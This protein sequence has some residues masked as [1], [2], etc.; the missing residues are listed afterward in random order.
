[1][2]GRAAATRSPP[3]PLA[4]TCTITNT[5]TSATLILQKQWVN[6]A[7]GDTAGLTIATPAPGTPASATSTATGAAGSET[8]T[9]NRAT[10]TVFSGQTVHPGRDA[11]CREHR[12]VHLADRL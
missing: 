7:A 1:M 3:T 8:D 11:G 5:R 4:A 10:A 2:T 6:G 12:V 9:V